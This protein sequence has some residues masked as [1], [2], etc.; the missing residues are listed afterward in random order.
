MFHDIKCGVVVVRT[1]FDGTLGDHGAVDLVDNVIDQ[2]WVEGIRDQ[3]IAGDNVLL[4]LLVAVA[5]WP[6]QTTASSR[7]HHR[8][9]C[10]NVT[11]GN[12]PAQHNN[13]PYLVNNHF[14]CGISKM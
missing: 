14:G 9:D 11:K 13:A 8:L 10:R 4:V 1:D 3:L 5:K 12:C 2:L 7:G 6:A